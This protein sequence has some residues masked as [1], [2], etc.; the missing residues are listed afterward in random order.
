VHS[1]VNGTVIRMGLRKGQ[2]LTPTTELYMIVNL[3]TAWVY[4]DVYEYELPWI[5][6]NDKV[7]MRLTSVPGKVFHGSIEYIYPYAEA[8]T[9]TTKIRLVFDNKKGL[10][11]PDMFANLRIYSA[12]QKN[13]LVI[14]VEAVVRSGDKAQV[15]IQKEAGKFEPRLVVLGNESGGEISILAGL[16][17]GERVV[18]SAQFLIDS[19][20]KLR[21]A[22]QKMLNI[23]STKMKMDSNKTL[24]MRVKE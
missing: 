15:F 8:K 22:T 10:L 9:R 1:P 19:E 11:R 4:A 20:S 5:K 2:Y 6:P 18:T 16:Q 13:A 17:E 3:T 21:E 12:T 7:E 23:N 24:D 14:P